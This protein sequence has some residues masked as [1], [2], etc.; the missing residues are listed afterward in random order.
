M[1]QMIRRVKAPKAKPRTRS[2]KSKSSETKKRSLIP[3]RNNNNNNNNNNNDS[4]NRNGN[5]H[6]QAKSCLKQQRNIKGETSMSTNPTL[7]KDEAYQRSNAASAPSYSRS[8]ETNPSPL[9]TS[10]PLIYSTNNSNINSIRTDDDHDVM[11]IMNPRCID[12]SR[13]MIICDTDTVVRQSM[14]S[15]GRFNNDCV[16]DIIS[17][18]GNMIDG[19]S[20]TKDDLND[21][22]GVTNSTTEED[23][24]VDDIISLF[25]NMIDGASLTKD[26][27]NDVFRVTNS[28][29]EEDNCTVVSQSSS[30]GIGG[31]NNS[32]QCRSSYCSQGGNEED[33]NRHSDDNY[34]TDDT[35]LLDTDMEDLLLILNDHDDFFTDDIISLFGTGFQ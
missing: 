27:L 7:S 5:S 8:T 31:S 12:M 17:L 1:T 21:V 4:S 35:C 23:D 18:F 16:D 6:T 10:F 29:T 2:R 33:K 28:T 13:D 30:S 19:A 26:D 25:G 20:L 32:Q 15:P 22:L 9:C 34:S 11:G 14:L 3:R 24:C